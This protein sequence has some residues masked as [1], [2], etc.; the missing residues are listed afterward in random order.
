M[1]GPAKTS[2]STPAPMKGFCWKLLLSFSV[3]STLRNAKHESS[4]GVWGQAPQENFE[5][6]DTQIC[7][8]RVFYCKN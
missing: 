8:L 6:L 4:G 7:N 1:S 5:K 3:Q 2:H